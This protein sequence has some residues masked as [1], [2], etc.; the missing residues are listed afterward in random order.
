MK[1]ANNYRCCW[2]GLL[3][4]S[5]DAKRRHLVINSRNAT[6][7]YLM[8]LDMSLKLSRTINKILKSLEEN[9]LMLDSRAFPLNVQRPS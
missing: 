8:A 1:S 5:Q 7:E 6:A 4:N 2:Y 9:G 3:K